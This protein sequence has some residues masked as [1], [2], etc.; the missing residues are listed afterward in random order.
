MRKV[1][2][3]GKNVKGGYMLF[4]GLY[5]VQK[6]YIDV[7]EC[8]MLKKIMMFLVATNVVANRPPERRSTGMPTTPAY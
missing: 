7:Q 2:N 5:A 1:D 4:R 8:Y 3:G 6:G